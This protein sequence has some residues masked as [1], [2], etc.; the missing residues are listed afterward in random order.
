MTELLAPLAVVGQEAII[1]LSERKQKPRER[2]HEY[3]YALITLV[4]RCGI[5]KAVRAH[6]CALKFFLHGLRGEIRD[7]LRIPPGAS[8]EEAVIEAQ[9]VE[10]TLL[11][12]EN[13]SPAGSSSSAAETVSLG[14]GALGSS[15][16]KYLAKMGQLNDGYVNGLEQVLTARRSTH[17]QSGHGESPGP[18]ENDASQNEGQGNHEDE[19]R[20][21]PDLKDAG[22]VRRRG[23]GLE[24]MCVSKGN[25]H[26]GFEAHESMLN[27]TVQRIV[28]P[29]AT[30]KNPRE[31]LTVAWPN[32]GRERKEPLQP[33]MSR[34]YGSTEVQEAVYGCAEV[35]ESLRHKKEDKRETDVGEVEELKRIE[36][37]LSAK[38]SEVIR[39]KWEP[40]P[41]RVNFSPKL[42]VWILLSSESVTEC[43]PNK[44]RRGINWTGGIEASRRGVVVYNILLGVWLFILN[45]ILSGVVGAS[46]VLKAFTD[47]GRLKGHIEADESIMVQEGLSFLCSRVRVRC[48]LCWSRPGHARSKATTLARSESPGRMLWV[49]RGD[50]LYLPPRGMEWWALTSAVT[51]SDCL[52]S[53]RRHLGATIACR[54]SVPCA[55]VVFSV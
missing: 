7:R 11:D 39:L 32:Q 3:A 6:E 43:V 14:N 19:D 49:P 9:A 30:P 51:V 52:A 5:V 13:S 10:N 20:E 48:P 54:S 35:A 24:V 2:C 38:D 21:G 12:R 8:F 18:R 26:G 37:R 1:R 55:H 44:A 50:G 31:T 45:S 17:S 27:W 22:S 29:R 16:V 41:P 25:F 33:S 23:Q 15:M 53:G 28:M 4:M 47:V 42:C 46:L 40:Y 36:Y 34:E